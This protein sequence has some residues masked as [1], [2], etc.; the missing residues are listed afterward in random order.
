MDKH[1]YNY[2]L[3]IKEITMDKL[4]SCPF[5]GGEAVHPMGDGISLLVVRCN[6]CGAKTE[7]SCVE[8]QVIKAWNKRTVIDKAI[9]YCKQFHKVSHD[10]SCNCYYCRVIKILQGGE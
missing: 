10:K 6:D 5:C 3:T 1:S 2:H 7:S 8:Q 9:T 4:K